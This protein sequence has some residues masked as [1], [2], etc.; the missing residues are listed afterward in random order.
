[1]AAQKG[2]V[3][4]KPRS[5]L[6]ISLAKYYG[7][8]E[9]RVL[10]MARMLNG[11]RNFTVA[12]LQGSA[13]HKKLI[14][15][16]LPHIALPFKRS[17][18]RLVFS[19][20]EIIQKHHYQVIDTHNPQSHFW[21][22]FAAKLA[23]VKNVISTV[24]GCYGDAETGW[25]SW[26][27]NF[28]LCLN[29]Y[30]GGQFI[31]V[32]ESVNSYLNKLSIKNKNISLIVNAISL[33]EV[34]GDR[35]TINKLCSWPDDSIIIAVAAR[36]EPVKGLNDLIAAFALARRTNQKLKL[37]IIGQGRTQNALE[38]QAAELKLED[39]IAFTGFRQDVIPLLSTAQIFCLPSISEGLPYAVL[40]A[41]L[42]RLPLAL[43]N[44]GG[45]AKLFKDNE[46]AL[47]FPPQNALEQ[48]RVLLEL[49]DSFEERKRLGEA[50]FQ[51]VEQNFSPTTM[52]E[53]VISIYDKESS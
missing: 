49:A 24:H 10:Y 5:I 4:P 15:E 34:S 43:S 28:V 39:N 16:N 52:F 33:T 1:M 7:G 35:K 36:L 51:L 13:L 37:C 12:V 31:A 48:S 20:K 46:T 40:E 14:I 27:Y 17:D 29:N 44:V 42:C 2:N 23:G 18:P 9:V 3:I 45:L 19:L 8:A 6:L 47:F 53:Q 41:A 22:V 32:S 26:L 30:F 21:G 50:A 11:H 25:R 38:K